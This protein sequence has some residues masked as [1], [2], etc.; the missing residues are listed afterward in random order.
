MR[1][2]AAC[3]P[4]SEVRLPCISRRRGLVTTVFGAGAAWIGGRATFI[5]ACRG[6]TPS[7]SN[8]GGLA[9]LCSEWSCSKTIGD[10]CLKTLPAIESS[11]EYLTRAILGDAWEAGRDCSSRGAL[12]HLI[13]EQSQ[14]DFRDGRIMTVDG[15]MLSLTETRVYALAALASRSHETV[16]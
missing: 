11:K 3:W 5:A 15:W 14:N 2:C 9:A 16:E 8:S 12:T 13:R 6:R 4:L 10:A 7:L 1:I